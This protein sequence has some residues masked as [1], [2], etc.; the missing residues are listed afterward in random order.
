MARSSNGQVCVFLLCLSAFHTSAV[1]L[2]KGRKTPDMLVAG[3]LKRRS[4]EAAAREHHA[5]CPLSPN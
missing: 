3:K 5:K 1:L 4:W 2:H